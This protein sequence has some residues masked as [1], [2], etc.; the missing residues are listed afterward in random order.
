VFGLET[1]LQ[2][3]L[4]FLPGPL[5]GIGIY[6][7]YTFTDS[8]ASF[9][10][11]AGD[12]TLPGQSR[13]V[14]NV[15]ASYEKGGFMGRMAI[16]FHGSYVD[17]VGATNLLDRFYDTHTQMDLSFSQRVTRN[18]RG[19]LDVINL[20]DSLL[21]Y[22]QGVSDRPLQEEHYHWWLEFGAKFTF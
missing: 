9:P 21:R 19:Y 18:L 17:Q 11:H 13:H 7:N 1:A 5:D 14:G 12:S 22:F 20:N 16:N 10:S 8:S 4:T 2:N 3:Q 6:L 15:A